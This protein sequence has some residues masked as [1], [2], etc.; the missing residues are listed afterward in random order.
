M[1]GCGSDTHC[2][3]SAHVGETEVVF[4]R[5]WCVRL[6]CFS[7]PSSEDD[8][9][10]GAGHGNPPQCSTSEEGAKRETSTSRMKTCGDRSFRLQ[11]VGLF[12]GAAAVLSSR[13]LRGRPFSCLPLALFPSGRKERGRGGGEGSCRREEGEGQGVRGAQLAK[14]H[15]DPFS[16]PEGAWAEGGTGDA[17]LLK[18]RKTG[19]VSFATRCCSSPG[20]QAR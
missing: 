7:L 5:F 2:D 14:F 3:S 9:G 15:A 4:H 10:H 12:P 20:K 8:G 1:H 17:L 18:S 6:L 19:T 13:R 16:D 11:M